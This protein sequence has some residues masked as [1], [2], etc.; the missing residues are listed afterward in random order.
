[1]HLKLELFHVALD[2][3]NAALAANPK[4][5]SSLYGRSLAKQQ[6]GDA[7]GAA[8]DMAAA[9]AIDQQIAQHFGK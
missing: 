2:D 4:L 1:M 7:R 6:L 3:Y 8:T 5:A 9:R